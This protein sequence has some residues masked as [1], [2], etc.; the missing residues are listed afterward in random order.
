MWR[1]GRWIGYF[2]GEAMRRW[3]VWGVW[4][5]MVLGESWA[6]AMKE[7]RSFVYYTEVVDQLV[8]YL[9]L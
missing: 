2:G 3:G 9:F 8:K 1:I 6:N 7:R 4:G 5:A